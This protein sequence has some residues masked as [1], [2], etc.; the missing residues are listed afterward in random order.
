GDVLAMLSTPAYEIDQFTGTI[1]RAAWQRVVQDPKFPLLN[2]VIQSQYAPGSIFKLLVAAAGLQEGTL[3]PGD[4]VQCNGEFRLGNATFK[5][6]KEG[7][8]GLVDT[9]HAIAQSCNIFFYQA[10]LKISGPVIA[11]YA[12]RSEEHTSEL[13]SLAYLV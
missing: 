2:R 6:W 12:Q 8:H 9:H 10:G 11:R 1:D 5:D 13:Q 7:G 4:R 3:T